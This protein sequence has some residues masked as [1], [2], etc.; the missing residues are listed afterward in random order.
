MS[1]MW[2]THII[3]GFADGHF[4][5]MY[6]RNLSTH[7]IEARQHPLL[8]SQ[9]FFEYLLWLTPACRMRGTLCF[10]DASLTYIRQ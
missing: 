9:H 4:C 10:Y 1:P 2:G 8:C 7:C 3:W 6:F 5:G